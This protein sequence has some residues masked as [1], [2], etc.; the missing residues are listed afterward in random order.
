MNRHKPDKRIEFVNTL[1]KWEIRR[2]KQAVS[3]GG[4]LSPVLFNIQMSSV[5]LPS[6]NNVKITTYADDIT[7]TTTG[8]DISKLETT[9]QP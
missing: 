7:I 8:P 4:I 5:P 9:V 3:E 2:M 1:V 6:I